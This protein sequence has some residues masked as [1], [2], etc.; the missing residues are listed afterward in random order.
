M[1]YSARIYSNIKWKRETLSDFTA[2]GHR[3]AGAYAA[4][5]CGREGDT[6]PV[7]YHEG[8]GEFHL[9]NDD[10]SY[11]IEIMENGQLGNLYYG[12]RIHDRDSFAYMH[13]QIPGSHAAVACPEPSKLSLQYVKQEL[14]SYGAGDF[15]YGAVT[16]EQENG[17]CIS[18]FKYASHIIYNGKKG[19]DPL[20]SV[21]T[22]NDGEASTLEIKLYDSVDDM[23]AVLIYTIFEGLPVI[24]RSVRYTNRGTQHLI[25][26][27]A[28]SVCTDLPDSDY[29]MLQLSGAWGRE[30]TV[31]SRELKPGIQ[32]VYSMRGASSAE[33]N[34]FLALKRPGTDENCGEVYAFSLIY[35][36]SFLAQ[37]EVCSMDTVRVLL[38]IHPDT[39][40]WPLDRGEVF[41][42]PEAVLVYSD[43]GLNKMSQTFHTLFRTRLVRGCWRDRERPVLLNNWEATEMDFSEDDLIRIAAK[44]R[45]AGIEL[46]V[47][48]DGWFGERNTD[49]AGLGDWYVNRKKLPDGID[50]LSK[51]IRA[52]GMS[53]GLWI[54]PEMVNKDSGLYREHPDWILSVPG[55]FESPSR[56]QFVLD[57]SREEVIS[58][59]FDRLD[60]VIGSADISYIKWDMNRYI[61]ECC[62]HTE[63]SAKQKTVM[64]RYILGVYELYSRL[65]RRYPEILFESCASGGA[66]FDPGML[67]YAPQAW[68]SDNTDAVCRERIQ[69]GTSYVYPISCMGSHVSAV[70]NMQTGRTTPIDTRADMAF[71]GAFGYEMDLNKISDSEME[72]VKRQIVWYKK[73]RKLLHTGTLFR[74]ISPFENNNVMSWMVV[75]QTKE[76]AVAGYYRVLN[77][78][79]TDIRSLK[80]QGLDE[81]ILYRVKAP[82]I[83][84]TRYGDEL[85]YS[86]IMLTAE[87]F[88]KHGG[89]FG[90]VLI[91]LEKEG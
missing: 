51:K 76:N 16:V 54:E 57:F 60:A 73:N 88:P 23:E 84:S 27:N 62:S 17:S 20:P 11:I 5:G 4:S 82:G 74:L 63:T 35:S 18:D 83:D 89:D 58:F 29:E 44:G 72:A 12:K 43:C 66:R 30:R 52:M 10:I 81:N 1:C 68:C 7:I 59:I 40:E 14:P 26:Q 22:E 3:T 78:P 86:G 48:D 64:H 21:Y 33:H 39:F 90:A 77:E 25:L 41:Q 91:E 55:R 24:T 13:H 8:A 31:I 42:S 56:N 36:G 37:A 70:P 71:F 69:Y 65:T 85:M 34:P 32:S 79:N 19:I 80:L 9:C 47:L 28:M 87:M 67:Y 15:R 75:D 50:G 46:F 49:H 61:T 6:M 38:G 2:A 53:F 45:E